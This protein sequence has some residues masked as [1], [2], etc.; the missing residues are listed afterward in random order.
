MGKGTFP[1]RWS[2]PPASTQRWASWKPSLE[3]LGPERQGSVFQRGNKERQYRDTALAVSSTAAALGGL[4]RVAG[5]EYAAKRLR[6]RPRKSS[7]GGETAP[8]PAL[9]TTLPSAG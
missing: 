7:S 2:W 3:A 4:F 5:F 8:P 9:Q 1:S 6:G